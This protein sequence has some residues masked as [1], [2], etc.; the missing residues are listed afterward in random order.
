MRKTL[1]TVVEVMVFLLFISHFNVFAQGRGQQMTRPMSGI[2]GIVQ[3]LEDT[4]YPLTEDQ[5]KSIRETIRTRGMWAG[6]ADILTPEQ[7]QALEAARQERA[8]LREE[9]QE[10]MRNTRQERMIAQFTRILENAG[11]PLS[12]DQIT[13]LK[14][15][16]PG[17]RIGT[18]LVDILTDEQQAALLDTRRQTLNRG[19]ERLVPRPGM[20]GRGMNRQGNFGGLGGDVQGETTGADEGGAAKETAVDAQPAFVTAI[21]QN[22]PN[23]FN[24]STTIEYTLAEPGNV[25]LDIFKDRKSVV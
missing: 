2:R 14:A 21:N 16:E 4:D 9:R 6:I 5:I 11:Y 15:I 22:Y 8:H 7:V 25:R 17:T 12:E 10:N 18:A 20:R 19:R 1:F 3:I 24:P 23:P 13:Q